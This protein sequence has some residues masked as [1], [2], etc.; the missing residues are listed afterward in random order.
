MT[1]KTWLSFFPNIAMALVT[2]NLCTLE[3]RGVGANSSTFTTVVDNYE[4]WIGFRAFIIDSVVL[5]LLGLFLDN[6]LPKQF[7]VK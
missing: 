4:I 2:T 3:N 7:G 5:L 1:I 6:V